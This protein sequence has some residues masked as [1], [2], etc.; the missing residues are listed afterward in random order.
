[1]TDDRTLDRAELAATA[2][3]RQQ[4][5]AFLEYYREV[6]TA[7][8]RGL[9]EQ[10]ARRRLVPSLTTPI[11]LAKHAAAVERGWF[12]HRLGQRPREEITGNSVG[13]GASWLVEPDESVAAVIAEYRAAC[14]ESRE[15]A[16]AFE[17]DHTVA[18]PRLGRVSLRWIYLHMI[19]ELARH[20]GHADILR[21]QI[22]GATGD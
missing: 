8:L 11:G 13:D 22:D 17:L 1:M 14:A 9:G 20:C 16:S 2:G 7:K 12:Q 4:L 5:E 3:E 6:I 10:D 21:E 15:V 18:H 19:E